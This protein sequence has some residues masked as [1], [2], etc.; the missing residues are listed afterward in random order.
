MK[1]WEAMKALEEGKRVR[2]T[3]WGNSRCYITHSIHTSL[4]HQV[5]VREMGGEWELYEEPEKTYSFME[6]VRGL[7]EG[8][9][10]KR[11]GWDDHT[12]PFSWDAPMR[13]PMRYT[14][15]T[16]KHFFSLND[17]EATDWVEVK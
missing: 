3:G 13:S 6:V 5:N 17:F 4:I 14:E 8:K 11:K 16:E 7:R 1:F 2:Y 15:R 9:A 12:R 10:Y